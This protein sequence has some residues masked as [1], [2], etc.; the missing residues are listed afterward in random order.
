M[1]LS[2]EEVKDWFLSEDEKFRNTNAIK[3][4]CISTGKKTTTARL[5]WFGSQIDCSSP[6]PINSFIQNKINKNAQLPSLKQNP[7]EPPKSA[8]IEN[9]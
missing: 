1:G 4:D 6:P 2:D 7:K 9:Q 8:A 3:A 5:S